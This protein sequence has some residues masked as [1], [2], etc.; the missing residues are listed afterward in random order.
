MAASAHLL[1]FVGDF[2]PDLHALLYSHGAP[3]LQRYAGITGDDLVACNDVT[4]PTLS[5]AYPS[6]LPFASYLNVDETHTLLL[7]NPSLLPTQLVGIA[8]GALGF[9]LLYRQFR[10]WA[11]DYKR[12]PNRRA[13]RTFAFAFLFFACMN[14]TSVVAHNLAGGPPPPRGATR[15]RGT[16]RAFSISCAQASRRYVWHSRR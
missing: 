4:E 13:Q 5:I 12:R 9:V 2:F 6:A 14:A 1:A 15:R 11:D 7:R 16:W 10:A 8:I 3:L